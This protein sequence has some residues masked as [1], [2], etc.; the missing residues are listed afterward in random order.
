[1]F[2]AVA[3]YESCGRWYVRLMVLMP[4]HLHAL[5]AVP[6]V[7]AL[8]QVIGSWKRYLAKTAA[9]EWQRDFFDHRLRTGENLEEKSAYIRQNPV[10]AGLVARP[11]DWPYVWDSHG[12]VG[13]PPVRARDLTSGSAS[14]VP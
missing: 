9:I 3:A 12:R 10:R 14:Q 4:D 11:E 2:E 6:A 13:S 5:L 8:P 7:E 1:M